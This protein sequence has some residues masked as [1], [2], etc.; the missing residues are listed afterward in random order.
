MASTTIT[1]GSQRQPRA[2]LTRIIEQ[3]AKELEMQRKE[4]E[5]VHFSMDDLSLLSE[6]GLDHLY[7]NQL[8]QDEYGALKIDNQY[9][10]QEPKRGF[11][12]ALGRV[13]YDGKN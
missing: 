9:I 11:K 1:R 3:L 4:H 12:F 5:T 7:V 2:N 8:Q 13:L 10:E 6:K